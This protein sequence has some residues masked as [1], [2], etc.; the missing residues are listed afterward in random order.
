MPVVLMETLRMDVGD[1]P[2]QSHG[3]DL[4]LAHIANVFDHQQGNA[5]QPRQSP[6]H[7]EGLLGQLQ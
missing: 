1:E 2:K 6:G 5:V 7:G 3:L 4:V